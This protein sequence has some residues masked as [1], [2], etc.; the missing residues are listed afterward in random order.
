MIDIDMNNGVLAVTFAGK[1]DRFFIYP[2]NSCQP[3]IQKSKN[4]RIHIVLF[5]KKQKLK[6]TINP[7][8][9]AHRLWV[10]YSDNRE[11]PFRVEAST[12]FLLSFNLWH[13]GDRIQND[14]LFVK[15]TEFFALP[16]WSESG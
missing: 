8:V 10:A 2:I 5:D 11:Y 13:K 9:W 15:L 6:R 12:K 14:A 4:G 3:L 1:L 16:F 7:V